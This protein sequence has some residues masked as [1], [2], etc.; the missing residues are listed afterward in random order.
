MNRNSG[1]ECVS[2]RALVLEQP[3]GKLA[4]ECAFIH[5]NFGRGGC[6]GALAVAP[7]PASAHCLLQRPGSDFD[8]K[9]LLFL[10]GLSTK[11]RKTHKGTATKAAH[12]F[13]FL[14]FR[15]FVPCVF[16][17]FAF[18]LLGSGLSGL[19]LRKTGPTGCFDGARGRL[20]A[21]DAGVAPY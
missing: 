17:T 14:V 5:T 20:I 16:S 7:G 8:L 13:R 3:R 9:F 11:S 18:G 2:S 12:F 10:T 4:S 15:T 21:P 19:R 6:R 1:L